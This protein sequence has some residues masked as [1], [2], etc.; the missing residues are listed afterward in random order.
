MKWK[1]KLEATEVLVLL[2]ADI[3]LLVL[4]IWGVKEMIFVG[5]LR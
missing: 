3:L 1:R 4:T 2:V 5:W